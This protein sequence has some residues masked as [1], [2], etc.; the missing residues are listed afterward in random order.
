MSSPST[1]KANAHILQNTVTHDAVHSANQNTLLTHISTDLDA[2]NLLL[3]DLKT[4]TE[5]NGGIYSAQVHIRDIN[6]PQ[7]HSDVNRIETANQSN[8][9]ALG[10]KTDSTN[11]KLDTLNTTLTG[12][13]VVNI[14]TLSTNALQTSGNATLSSILVDTTAI[15]G[16]NEQ[17]ENHIETMSENQSTFQSGDDVVVSSSA[18]PSGASTSVN[19]T[20]MITNST[21]SWGTIQT[22]EGNLIVTASS[23]HS[24]SS[25]FSTIPTK[26]ILL[27]IKNHSAVTNWFAAIEGSIDN[28][29]WLATTA[30][31]MP[32]INLSGLGR[33]PAQ[34]GVAYID[35]PPFPYL[36]VLITNADGADRGYEIKYIQTN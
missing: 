21:R 13:S 10:T 9:D 23:T 4:Q 7:L 1:R 34:R 33:S 35:N 19:Q 8:F 2:A 6:L 29:T 36:R 15:K 20:T 14:T 26:P 31:N 28:T 24:G 30:Q 27:Y 12:G 32:I 5:N 25:S 3:T 22:V 11:T 16:T 17:I 18:L